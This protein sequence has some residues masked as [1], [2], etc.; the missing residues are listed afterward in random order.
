[1]TN[2]YH[3]RWQHKVWQSLKIYHRQHGNSRDHKSDINLL[4]FHAS[5]EKNEHTKEMKSEIDLLQRAN[6]LKQSVQFPF[7][8]RQKRKAS[9]FLIIVSLVKLHF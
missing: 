8:T 1:M 4:K 9:Y 7:L 5:T 2:D 3:Y 6:I